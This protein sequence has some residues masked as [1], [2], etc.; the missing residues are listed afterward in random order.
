M[1]ELMKKY[2][3]IRK[4]IEAVEAAALKRVQ[5][6]EAE[7]AA[8]LAAEKGGIV[9]DIRRLVAE[10]NLT[11]RDLFGARRKRQDPI[12]AKYL[13]PASGATWSGR[14]RAPAWI[15]GKKR[16]RFLISPEG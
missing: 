4:E 15:A 2:A 13:D 16:E 12:P 5:E 6:L 8:A 3:E 10:Y 9:A 14:G 11:A 7:A 1:K